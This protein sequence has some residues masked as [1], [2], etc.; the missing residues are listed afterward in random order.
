MNK[1]AK[2]ALAVLCVIIIAIVI[3]VAVM[4][5]SITAPQID[6][7]TDSQVQLQLQDA[8]QTDL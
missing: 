5:K 3:G 8:A 2:I 7:Q 4:Q 1:I 6:S